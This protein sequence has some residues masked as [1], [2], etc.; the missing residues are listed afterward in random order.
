MGSRGW[1]V[2]VVL[3]RVQMLIQLVWVGLENLHF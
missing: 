1:V 3:V 2:M